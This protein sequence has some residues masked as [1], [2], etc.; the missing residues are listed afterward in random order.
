METVIRLRLSELT[1][2]TVEKIKNILRNSSDSIDPQITIV[3]E[4]DSRKENEYFKKLSASI[5]QAKQGE[6]VSFTMEE[7]T[8]Y[9]NANFG[10]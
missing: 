10:Q 3:L 2:A 7:L 6:T 9:V 4:D 8:E 5:E 1:T